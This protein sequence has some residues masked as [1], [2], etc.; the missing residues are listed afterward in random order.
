MVASHANASEAYSGSFVTSAPLRVAGKEL[1]Q[2]SYQAKWIESGPTGEVKILQKGK[3]VLS[4][5]ARMK[6]LEAR[7]SQGW[8]STRTNADNTLSLASLEFASQMFALFF[9]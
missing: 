8:V 1:P 4:V 2:G 5:Q 9:E 3:V 7:P 6:M